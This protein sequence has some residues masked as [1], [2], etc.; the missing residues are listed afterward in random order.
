MSAESRP[1]CPDGDLEAIEPSIFTPTTKRSTLTSGAGSRPVSGHFPAAGGAAD[2]AG[3]PWPGCTP[4]PDGFDF[5]PPQ[6][7]ATSA[8]TTNSNSRGHRIARMGEGVLYR[9]P[10]L[11][12]SVRNLCPIS[13]LTAA[14]TSSRLHG[15]QQS[16]LSA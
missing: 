9:P 16:A 10:V 14:W 12:P 2:C 6:A 15:L 8:T 3:R 7:A 13:E 11:D 1:D 5:P 4:C